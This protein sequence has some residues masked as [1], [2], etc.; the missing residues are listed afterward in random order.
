[1]KK[2][3]PLWGAIFWTKLDKTTKII[4]DYKIKNQY[5]LFQP[6]LLRSSYKIKV[7]WSCSYLTFKWIEQR[8]GLH[9]SFHPVL[10]DGRMWSKWTTWR[11]WITRKRWK[12]STQPDDL[13]HSFMIQ[14]TLFVTQNTLVCGLWTVQNSQHLHIPHIWVN[15]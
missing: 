9:K 7:F 1:M 15:C 6:F 8:A 13:K 3:L 5:F 12:T 11:T 2:H 14:N 4:Q 10:I